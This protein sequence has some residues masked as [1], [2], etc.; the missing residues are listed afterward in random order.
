MTTTLALSASH[1]GASL[2]RVWIERRDLREDD[3]LIDI[4]Y[5]G[6]CHSDIHQVNEDWGP[7]IFPMVPGHELTGVVAAVGAKVTSF[8]VGDRVGVGCYVDSC[9]TCESCLQGREQMCRN[10]PVATYNGREYDG[11]PTAGGYSRSIVVKDHF[12]MAIPE[13]MDFAA[14]AP[15]LCAGIT[16]YAPLARHGVAGKNIAIIGMGGLGHVA[17]KI[18]HA[19]GATVTV[20]SQ[21][22][23]KAADGLA[24]GADQYFATSDP[25]TFVQ[26]EQSFDLVLNTVSADIALD[27]Y[28]GTLKIDGSFVNVGFPA[29][30]YRF[31]A[32]SLVMHQRSIIG[33]N[34][35]GPAQ[36]QEMLNFCAQ[37][38]IAAEIELI[39]VDEIAD[40]YERV[41]QSTVRYRAVIDIARTLIADDTSSRESL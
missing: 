29:E 14:A 23:S 33:S 24:F 2:S 3:V 10:V 13:G 38:G 30:P 18:A 31:H 34:V 6:I 25:E 35:G 15:L 40:A 36:T 37:H 8:R 41:A 19:L 26:L 20:L 27:D 17:V 32:A 5:A 22:L 7:A 16:V 11:T 28:L 21:S 39:G 12:V 9:G 1:P 4:A